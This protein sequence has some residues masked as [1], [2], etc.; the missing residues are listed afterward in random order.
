MG[1]GRGKTNVTEGQT[2]LP[3]TGT[4]QKCC[5]VI[6][7]VVY[8]CSVHDMDT[9]VFSRKVFFTPQHLFLYIVL[10]PF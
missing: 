3:V 5:L 6:I 10:R 9:Q 7:E 1:E 4:V 8:M 2:G